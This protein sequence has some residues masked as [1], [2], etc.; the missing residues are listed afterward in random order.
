MNKA[1]REDTNK[2]PC[3]WHKKRMQKSGM[4]TPVKT[5]APYKLSYQEKPVYATEKRS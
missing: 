3:G 5:N 4:S 2:C 1:N